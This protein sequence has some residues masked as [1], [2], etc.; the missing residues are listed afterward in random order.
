ME[1]SHNFNSLALQIKNEWIIN[2]IVSMKVYFEKKQI[3]SQYCIQELIAILILESIFRQK[4][5]YISCK[6][7]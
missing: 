1:D 6:L 5:V 2:F 3:H 7:V 4:I